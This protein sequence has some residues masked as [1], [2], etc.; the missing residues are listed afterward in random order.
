M[1]VEVSIHCL[2]SCYG[3]CEVPQHHLK[4][5]CGKL[6][7]YTLGPNA[8]TEIT[9]ERMLLEASA[10]QFGPQYYFFF[11]FAVLHGMQ[12]LSS[13]TRDQTCAPTTSYRKTCMKFLVESMLSPICARSLGLVTFLIW[14]IPKTSK[15]ICAIR[16]NEWMKSRFFFGYSVVTGY[17]LSLTFK[18]L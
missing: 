15:W 1:G 18:A 3:L 8:I 4:V 17:S 13:S 2:Q 12:D 9:K 7:I 5:N 11:S 14:T 6:K 10:L 16:R